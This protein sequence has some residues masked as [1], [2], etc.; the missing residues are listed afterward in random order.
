[1]AIER[2]NS[3]GYQLILLNSY[4]RL[5][6]VKHLTFKP[7]LHTVETVGEHVCDHVLRGFK[8]VNMSTANICCE[9]LVPAIITTIGI[10]RHMW[11]A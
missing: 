4:S 11:K 3:I 1:M 8:V 5:K 10:P 2:S 6:D 7:G 9:I